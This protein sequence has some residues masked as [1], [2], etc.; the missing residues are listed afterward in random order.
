MRTVTTVAGLRPL[1]QEWRARHERIALVP[2]M[3]G[4]HAGH[5]RLVER[6]LQLGDRVVASIFVNP[7][8]FAEGEDYGRYPRRPAEDGLQLAESGVHLLFSPGVEEMYPGG[9]RGV[10]RVEVPGLGE[11]LCGASRPGHFSGVA[12]VVAKLLN[13]VQPDVALFG[14]K[15]FQQLLVIRRMVR[16]LC[17]PVDIVGVATCR[18]ED[19]LAMSSRNRYL[20]AEERRVAPG[21]YR[22]LCELRDRVL[23]GSRD[24]RRLEQAAE[25]D[26]HRLG[27]SPDYVSV[28]Q[29]K[30]LAPPA[31]AASALIVLAAA[32][33]GPARLID[34]VAFALN[35]MTQ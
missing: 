33:L 26:L 12:T 1:I 35:T 30:D 4:L 28:R 34:N 6:A 29:Q 19:G 23:A 10:V 16:E 21:L 8:Q 31:P 17:F 2:T 25:R 22:V 20:S 15:D 18:E 13:V 9:L 3:G 27:F 11:A 32:R 5:M 24:Y 14:E 7:T